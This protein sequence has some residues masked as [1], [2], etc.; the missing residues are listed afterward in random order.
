MLSGVGEEIARNW[1]IIF[2]G[3]D[4]PRLHISEFFPQCHHGSII[5]TTRNPQFGALSPNSHIE[6]DIMTLKEATD[7]L[8]LSAQLQNPSESERTQASVIS[9]A[10]GYLPVALVQAGSFIRV[11]HCLDNYL[12]RL[13]RN[14]EKMMRTKALYQ[15]DQHHHCVYDTLDITYPGLSRDGQTLLGILSFVNHNGFPSLLVERASSF[16][17]RYEPMDLPD[18]SPYFERS[19]KTLCQ[20]FMPNNSWDKQILDDRIC[21]LEQ[22]SL[23]TRME[24]FKRLG[25]IPSRS[26]PLLY[27][28]DMRSGFGSHACFRFQ[29]FVPKIAALL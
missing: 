14:R 9:Q 16:D 4:D 7:A 12:D 23:I 6:V 2:D 20:V 27:I 13:N 15:R 1:A 17:F 26:P 28:F 3:C 8:L 19:I 29:R 24:I 18:R 21:E 11:N 25:S 22:Y 10:L 5:I